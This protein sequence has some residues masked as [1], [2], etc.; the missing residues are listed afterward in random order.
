MTYMFL[1]L[2][3]VIRWVSE[4]RRDW[5]DDLMEIIRLSDWIILEMWLFKFSIKSLW[6]GRQDEKYLINNSNSLF[7]FHYYLLFHSYRRKWRHNHRNDRNLLGTRQFVSQLCNKNLE[8]FNKIVDILK[9]YC[10][11]RFWLPYIS[12]P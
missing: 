10:L 2:L 12:T 9:R 7:Y 3:S 11:E 4:I 5:F 1:S 6:Y 8:K